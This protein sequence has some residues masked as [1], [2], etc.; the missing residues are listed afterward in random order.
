M[1]R[2]YQGIRNKD[3]LKRARRGQDVG[4]P[5]AKHATQVLKE[6]SRRKIKE[7]VE[8]ERKRC[9]K[10]LGIA[11]EKQFKLYGRIVTVE[12]IDEASLVKI[13]GRGGRFPPKFFEP[14]KS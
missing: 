9:I 11:P 12:K 3:K 13:V 4:F 6:V 8:P 7:K 5:F 10:K 2:K 14:M 1:S